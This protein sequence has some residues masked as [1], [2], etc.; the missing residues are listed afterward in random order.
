[1]LPEMDDLLP[2]MDDL[3]PEMEDLM[4]EMDNLLPKSYVT[5]GHGGQGQSTMATATHHGH[6]SRPH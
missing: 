3:L 6:I 2:E 1:M 4:P 5:P